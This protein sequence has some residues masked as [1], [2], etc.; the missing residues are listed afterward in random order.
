MI[1]STRKGPFCVVPAT[2][3]DAS[4]LRPSHQSANR[5]GSLAFLKP[6]RQFGPN[7][8]LYRMKGLES[9]EKVSISELG[10]LQ[11]GSTVHH[12]LKLGVP[13]RASKR[14]RLKW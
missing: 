5:E 3:P 7:L 8:M 1:D 11:R 4:G 9:Q 2:G 10:Y 14:I 13:N 6:I 12:G